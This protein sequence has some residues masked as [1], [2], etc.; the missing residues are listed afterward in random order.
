[1][2]LKHVQYTARFL[3]VSYDWAPFLSKLGPGGSN[4]AALATH[5]QIGVVPFANVMVTC[6]YK[7][8]AMLSHWAMLQ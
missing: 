6:F 8:L 2:P 3:L 1:M 4:V 7:T 5:L